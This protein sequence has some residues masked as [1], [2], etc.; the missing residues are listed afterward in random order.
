LSM[1]AGLPARA[2]RGKDAVFLTFQ[3]DVFKESDLR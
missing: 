2:W 3:A 1:K